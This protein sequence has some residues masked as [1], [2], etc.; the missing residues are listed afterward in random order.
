MFYMEV[1][2]NM[3]LELMI[4]SLLVFTARLTND[5]YRINRSKIYS[6]NTME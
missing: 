6:K 1:I 5:L 3:L 4:I 2:Y